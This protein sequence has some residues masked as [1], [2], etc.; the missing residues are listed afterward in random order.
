MHLRVKLTLLYTGVLA[1]VLVI[2]TTALHLAVS[3]TL[4]K[5]VDEGIA[6]RAT[7][8]FKS[9]RI[10]GGPF[11]LREVVLPDVDVFSTPDIYLQAVDIHGSV[12]AR[13]KNLGSQYIPL[14]EY[15]LQSALRGEKFYE[16]VIAAGQQIRI[17]SL[18]LIVEG[19]LVGLLQV[20]RTLTPINELL[21]RLRFFIIIVGM[22]ALILAAILGWVLARAALRPLE[23]VTQTASS[24]ESG[25][26]LSRRIDYSGPP[27]ELGRLVSTLNAMFERLQK[28]YNRLEES[29]ELQRRFVADASHE[30]R[31]PLTS[32]RGNAE[33]LLK[34]E[35]AADP[36]LTREALN[37][38]TSET[39]RL[40]RLV[41]DLLSLARADA[42]FE[43]KKETA[44]LNGLF[45]EVS[46]KAQFLAG[47]KYFTFI[48]YCPAKTVVKINRDY[49]G[50]LLFI[51]LDNAFKYSP[52]GTE[53]SFAAQLNVEGN[54]EISVAD[55]GPG[56]VPGEEKRI[57]DRFYRAESVRG[58]EGSGLGLAIAKWIVDQHNGIIQAANRPNGGSVFTITLPLM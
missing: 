49:F 35:G 39:R 1:L 15:T 23:R 16:T 5:E 25:S 33:L 38:I 3:H 11:S 47:D 28:L 46:R 36:Q 17:Y 30:L 14:S 32:I 48:N 34:M 20:G 37:D 13:S 53:V 56:L 44:L 57:F 10:E 40:T 9:I 8:V 51:L 22:T 41:Q 50:Q 29:Y 26:D 4:Y 12:V 31:T 54:V 18:P 58:R 55:Q 24:I 43:L 27:D 7:S 45:D 19:R 52:P 21:D 42:G 6:A 2:L